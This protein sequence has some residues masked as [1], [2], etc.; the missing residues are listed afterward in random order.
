MTPF[1]HSIRKACFLSLTAIIVSFQLVVGR[2]D[3]FLITQYTDEHGLPQNSIKGI[4]QDNLGFIWLICEKG[5]VRY[6]G[7][8]EF[9][10]F[11]DLSNALRTVRM[12]ALYRGERPDE[13]WAESEYGEPVLLKDGNAEVPQK[14][15]HGIASNF[16][17]RYRENAHYSYS[18]PSPNLTDIFTHVLVPDG[19]QGGFIVT[20]DSIS[21]I[22][23]DGCTSTSV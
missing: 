20:R 2:D 6:N 4:G 14:V 23:N 18:L 3:A 16:A 21:H 17:L 5:P 11:D 22:G 19:L 1:T 9:Q 15:P 13:L 8:G 12:S 10:T 7:R